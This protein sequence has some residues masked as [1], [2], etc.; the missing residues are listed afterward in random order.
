MLRLG[1]PWLLLFGFSGEAES[2]VEQGDY[3]GNCH[4]PRDT[5]GVL[6]AAN[7]TSDPNSVVGSW[8]NQEIARA[9]TRGSAAR[10]ACSSRKWVMFFMPDDA[11]NIAY[12]RP[13]PPLQ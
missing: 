11:A 2:A 6:M 13:V 12:L 3:C 7:I 1:L 10:D 5:N 4:T 8:N 9:I